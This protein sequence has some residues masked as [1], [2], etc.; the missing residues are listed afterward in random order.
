SMIEALR[1]IVRKGVPDAEESI[2]WNAPSF[3]IDGED[4]ITLGLDIRGGARLV[5]HRGA[6]IRESIDLTGVDQAKVAQWPSADRGYPSG[7]H[8]DELT[9]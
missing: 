9:A 8:R 6:K 7:E 1:A 2:K 5:M 4:R 3:A